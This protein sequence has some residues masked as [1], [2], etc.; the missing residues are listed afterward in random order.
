MVDP[1]T[2]IR[3]V[4][5]E[6]TAIDDPAEMVEAG[7]TDVQLLPTGWA[8]VDGPLGTLVNP[9]MPISFGAMAVHHITEEMVFSAPPA[10]E[11]RGWIAGE[12]DYICAHYIDFDA[13]FIRDHGLP[14]I[15]SYRVARTAWPDLQSYGNGAIRYQLGLCLDDDRAYP[16][17]R[18][19]PDTFITANILL[20]LL[21]RFTPAEMVDITAR[22]LL[23]KKID[24]GK[25]EGTAFADLPTDYLDWI[26]NKSN[27]PNDPARRDEV[28]TAR[29]E[30]AKRR[31]A[32]PP[33]NFQP[34]PDP[35]AWRKEMEH[36][37]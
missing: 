37:R 35:D 1:F 30:V 3:V 36:A 17:H 2:L 14:V 26:V 16:P 31:A 25:H 32:E 29:V 24:F 21:K 4:D 12:A 6:T 22:P 19:G 33:R 9:G 11:V 20:E 18:A 10:D 5:T 15:C 28:H 13:R 7:W 8:I 27:M 34:E 23:L